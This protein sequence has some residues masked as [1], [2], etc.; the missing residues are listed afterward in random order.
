MRCPARGSRSRLIRLLPPAER[1][2][3]RTP[4][5]GRPWLGEA[6]PRR[7]QRGGSLLSAQRSGT[8]PATTGVSVVGRGPVPRGRRSIIPRVWTMPNSAFERGN[9]HPFPG[10]ACGR[11]GGT[12]ASRQAGIEGP[13][14]RG[15]EVADDFS[16]HPPITREPGSVLRARVCGSSADHQREGTSHVRHH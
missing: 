4:A 11:E 9:R 3:R 5:E 14:T 7:A 10:G 16:T 1:A 8:G 2:K 12:S 15:G 6:E 13:R